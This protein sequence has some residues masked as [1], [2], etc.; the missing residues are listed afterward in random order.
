MPTT[1]RAA[2]R[3][4]TILEDELGLAMS[5]ALPAT[6][7]KDRE[8]LGEVAGNGSEDTVVVEDVVQ[9]EKKGGAKGKKAKRTKKGKK[10][11]K[12]ISEE[13]TPEVLEDD[14]QSA[15][16]SAVEEACGDLLKP[17]AGATNHIPM[18]DRPT[19]P[20]S[21][22]VDVARKRLTPKLQT[23]HFDPD[24]H[25]SEDTNM[26]APANDKEDSFVGAIVSRTPAKITRTEPFDGERKE[27]NTHNDSEDSFVENI[28]ARS[29]AKSTTRIEDSINAIDALEDAIEEI[30]ECLP[31]VS[32]DAQSPVTDKEASKTSRG[33]TKATTPKPVTNENNT[34]SAKPALK[35][36]PASRPSTV[37]R[38]PIPPPSKTLPSRRSHISNVRASLP[39]K[40]RSTP[41]AKTPRQPSTTKAS[42]TAKPARQLTTTNTSTSDKLPT[43]T[44]TAAKPL[45][46]TTSTPLAPPTTTSR[47]VSST[48][49]PPFHPTKSLKPPTRPSF[50]L[51]GDAISRKLKEA[52]EE[53]QRAEEAAAAQKRQFKARPVRLSQAPVLVKNT[54][55]SRA[56]MSVL[57]IRGVGVIGLAYYRGF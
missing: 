1:T 36:V 50:S 18:Q 9:L 6:P 44:S 21:P 30:G 25:G 16:S 22:A 3:S 4:T 26:K 29:P 12:I 23:P 5:T 13:A 41:P 52:R 11:P 10:Q 53:R 24:M 40:T 43:N 17:N 20:Q 7:P 14:D 2:L 28:V 48:H 39:A 34:A 47:P 15:T 35:K 27:E 8:P 49:K 46:T 45:S 38:T 32:A 56:R 54:A 33:Q 55:A 42:T 19:T 37:K 31:A 57:G 51:P